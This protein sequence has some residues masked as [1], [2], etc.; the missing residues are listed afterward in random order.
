M[1]HGAGLVRLKSTASSACA[2][3]LS[4]A[5]AAEVM[6][7]LHLSSQAQHNMQGKQP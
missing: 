5:A 2:T 1:L 4:L 3:A 7:T 6:H